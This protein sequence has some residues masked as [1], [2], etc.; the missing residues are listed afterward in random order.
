MMVKSSSPRRLSSAPSARPP[1]PAPT[2]S[3]VVVVVVVVL[4]LVVVLP[5]LQQL[6]PL[7]TV[8]HR[9]VGGGQGVL[10]EFLQ[11]SAV[12]GDHICPLDL[13]HIVHR[14]RI[15]VQAAHLTGAQPLH[16]HAVH[17]LRKG[18]GK[19]IDGVGGGQHGQPRLL[20]FPSA[21]SGRRTG[22]KQKHRQKDQA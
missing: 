6:H 11:L 13:L 18:A 17:I 15:V 22:R 4:P 10:H 7:G 2:M 14:Q 21:P 20:L 3:V 5:V 1:N 8:D 12:H 16:R 9:R 19:E